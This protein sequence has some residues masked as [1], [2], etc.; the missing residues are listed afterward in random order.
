MSE[1]PATRIAI[2]MIKIIIA[3][4]LLF[5]SPML[6]H[7]CPTASLWCDVHDVTKLFKLEPGTPVIAGRHQVPNYDARLLGAVKKGSPSQWSSK[8]DLLEFSG[9]QFGCVHNLDLCM[10]QT[11]KIGWV[12]DHP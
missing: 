6:A 5:G 4:S 3:V 8:D 12:P 10:N 2:N 11:L 9:K 7:D 1:Y